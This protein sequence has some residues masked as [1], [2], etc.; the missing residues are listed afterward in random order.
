MLRSTRRGRALLAAGATASAVAL[1]LT[2]QTGPMAVASGVQAPRGS[3]PITPLRGT[4]VTKAFFGMHSSTLMSFFPAAPVGSVGLMTDGVYWPDLETSPG[5]FDFTRLESLV[6]Q[7]ESH[8]AR[9]VLILGQ[10]PS[11]HAA[12]GTTYTGLAS[13]PDMTA[14]KSYVRAVVTEFGDRL[15]YE[16]WPEP[17]VKPNWVGTPQQMADLLVAAARIIHRT[18]PGAVVVA[19]GMVLRLRFELAFMKEFF[20]TKVNGVPVG[21]VIDAVGVDP[22]PLEDGGPEESLALIQKAQRIL[23]LDGVDAPI[24]TLEVNYGAHVGSVGTAEHSSW[25]QQASWVARTYLL[26]AGA[27]LTRVF[28]LGWGRF[29]NLDIQMV[30]TDLST[31]TPAAQG[32]A[33]VAQWLTGQGARGCFYAQDR[34]LYSCAFV[35][36][37]HISWAYWTTS[38][39][40]HVKAPDGA[41]KVQKITGERSAT[42]PGERIRVTTVPVWVTH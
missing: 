24:W 3:V 4:S 36:D 12:E 18:A 41:R 17:N 26:S 13:V 39:R 22:Y 10:T 11:F 15:D 2:V 7:A 30:D 9:P 32:Y 38:G 31:P 20:A 28:W 16:I 8:G 37:G 14:W 33:M 35:R 19:P 5:S 42:R 1:A 25:S 27:G 29:Q 21:R 40:S 6:Q 23:D 34:G